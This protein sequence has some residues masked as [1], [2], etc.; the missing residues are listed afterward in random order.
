MKT[1]TRILAGVLLTATATTPASAATIVRTGDRLMVS[2]LIGEG[3]SITFEIK[4][5]DRADGFLEQQ[6]R[7]LG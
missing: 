7:L 2:G 1:I 4:L 5:D 6:R 3:D